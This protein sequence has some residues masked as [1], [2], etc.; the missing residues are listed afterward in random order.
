MTS[1]ISMLENV[2]CALEKKVC[3][4]PLAGRMSYKYQLNLSGVLYHLKFVFPYLFSI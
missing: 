1:D 3:I 4:L 2:P